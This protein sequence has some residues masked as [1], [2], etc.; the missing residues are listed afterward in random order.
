MDLEFIGR[1]SADREITKI[2]FE[3]PSPPPSVRS[4]SLP[5]RDLGPSHNRSTCSL[6]YR[7]PSSLGRVTRASPPKRMVMLVCRH[8]KPSG[9]AGKTQIRADA[10]ADITAD[11]CPRGTH[12]KIYCVVQGL[13]LYRG[14]AVGRA[15]GQRTPE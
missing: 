10:S 5:V 11:E 9:G 6:S 2:T 4:A 1:S 12:A 8:A 15:V 13:R 14:S 7:S 3:P